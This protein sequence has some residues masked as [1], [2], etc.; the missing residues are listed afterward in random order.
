MSYP[1]QVVSQYGNYRM[2]GLTP[3][4]GYWHDEITDRNFVCIADYLTELQSRVGANPLENVV[5]DTTPQLGGNLDANGKAITDVNALSLSVTTPVAGN[6]IWDVHNDRDNDG[7]M[8]LRSGNTTDQRMYFAW[9]TYDGLT[10]QWFMGRNAANDFILWDAVNNCHFWRATAGAQL[11]LCSEGSAAVRV[12]A[13]GDLASGTGGLEVHSGGGSPQLV[14][15]FNSSGLDTFSPWAWVKPA[16]GNASVRVTSADAKAETFLYSA[17]GFDCTQHYFI[18]D[19]EQWWQRVASYG[20]WQLWSSSLSEYVINANKTTGHVG[21]RYNRDNVPPYDLTIENFLGLIESS[22]DPDEPDEGETVIWMSDGTEKGD[23]GDV[24]I[25][26]K[27]GGVTRW[28]TLFDHS[29]GA[30]W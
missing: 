29:G 16:A 18:D 24:L 13:Y 2:L 8:K 11:D 26:S 27:A 9:Q 21:I 23:D 28:G 6:Y 10:D 15:R 12:G 19:V 3:R 20:N 1:S 7:L 14:H 25:A 22:A 17:S 4:S 5:E 30:A